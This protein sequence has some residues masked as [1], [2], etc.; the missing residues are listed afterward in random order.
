MSK[1][2]NIKETDNRHTLTTFDPNVSKDADVGQRH[3]CYFGK[4]KDDH[5]IKI[6][7]INT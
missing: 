7:S 6:I 1:S 4:H 3:V 2:K 5:N